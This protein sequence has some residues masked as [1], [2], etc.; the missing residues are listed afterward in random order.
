MG[1]LAR[2]VE[3]AKYKKVR[4]ETMPFYTIRSAA[5]TSARTIKLHTFIIALHIHNMI[6]DANYVRCDASIQSMSCRVQSSVAF[7]LKQCNGA[8]S[9]RSLHKISCLD[10]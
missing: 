2:L 4:V 3:T 1:M 8:S 7:E 5:D 6:Q 9:R 10:A